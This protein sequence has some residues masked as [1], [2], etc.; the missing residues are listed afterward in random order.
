[1]T[2][3]S[4]KNIFLPQNDFIDIHKYPFE[5]V[6]LENCDFIIINVQWKISLPQK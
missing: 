2:Y 5:I 3:Y 1:M 4:A 6:N